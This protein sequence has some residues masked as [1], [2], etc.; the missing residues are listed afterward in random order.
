MH[1]IFA[2]GEKTGK[3]CIQTPLCCLFLQE[4]SC[5]LQSQS[6]SVIDKAR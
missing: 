1:I 5:F 4:S 2:T 3:S 6:N